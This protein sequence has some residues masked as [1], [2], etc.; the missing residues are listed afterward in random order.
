MAV[1]DAPPVA[2]AVQ[3]VQMGQSAITVEFDPAEERPPQP[4]RATTPLVDPADATDAEE[5]LQGMPEH[6]KTSVYSAT[7]TAVLEIKSEV[8]MI[9]VR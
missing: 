6:M 4:P 5:L 8:A 7:D 9:N 3:Q 1:P 2:G